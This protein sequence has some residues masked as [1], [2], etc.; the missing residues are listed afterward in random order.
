MPIRIS[1]G[2]T[3][4]GDR[5]A[6]KHGLIGAG[7]G[8]RGSVGRTDCCFVGTNVTKGYP[9]AVAINRTSDTA[10]IKPMNTM[11]IMRVFLACSS[12]SIGTTTA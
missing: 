10:A 7:I 2:R 8:N 4:E 1:A 9:I 3:V 5:C 12:N 6:G 11:N